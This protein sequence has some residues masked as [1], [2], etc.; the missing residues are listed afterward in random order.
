ME[1]S[2]ISRAALASAISA[3][4]SKPLSFYISSCG[5]ECVTWSSWEPAAVCGDAI[6]CVG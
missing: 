4:A 5:C 2:T 1:N 6:G 3:S